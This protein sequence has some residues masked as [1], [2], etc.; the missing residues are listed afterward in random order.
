MHD[1]RNLSSADVSKESSTQ[2]PTRSTSPQQPQTPPPTT[3]SP[4]YTSPEKA[5]E[6]RELHPEELTAH[7][8]T[9]GSQAVV[10]SSHMLSHLP[11]VNG[12]SVEISR[13]ART[14]AE[15]HSGDQFSDGQAT[16]SSPQELQMVVNLKAE[17]FHTTRLLTQARQQARAYAETCSELRQTC[18]GLEK[19]KQTLALE[20]QDARERLHVCQTR[21]DE[22]R[23]ETA[24]AKLKVVSLTAERD[25]LATKV[26]EAWDRVVELSG[27]LRGQEEEVKRLQED[28]VEARHGKDLVTQQ[29]TTVQSQLHLLQEQLSAGGADVRALEVARER[30][31]ASL[32][33]AAQR[34]ADVLSDVAYDYQDSVAYGSEGFQSGSQSGQ[35]IFRI[36]TAST[37]EEDAAAEAGRENPPHVVLSPAFRPAP[38]STSSASPH[39]AAEASR[40]HAEHLL[41][42][43]GAVIWGDL[44]K[45]FVEEVPAPDRPSAPLQH[46][47][48]LHQQLNEEGPRKPSEGAMAATPPEHKSPSAAQQCVTKRHHTKLSPSV[49]SLHP[50]TASLSEQVFVRTALAP[51]LLSMKHVAATLGAVRHEHRRTVAEAEHFHRRLEET[52]RELE[53]TQKALRGQEAQSGTFHS[54]VLQLQQQVQQAEEALRQHESQDTQRRAELASVLRC[55][56]D[57]A[58]IQHSVERLLVQQ[59]ELHK[60]LGQLEAA[61][62]RER[63]DV[64][65]NGERADASRDGHLRRQ[66]EEHERPQQQKTDRE[67][68][69][70]KGG[71]SDAWR[72]QEGQ[73]QQEIEAGVSLQA[74]A[75]DDLDAGNPAHLPSSYAQRNLS[76]APHSLLGTPRLHHLVRDGAAADVDPYAQL[77]AEFTEVPSGACAD[78]RRYGTL[79]APPLPLLPH[80]SS[81]VYTPT[82]LA[83]SHTSSAAQEKGAASVS[84]ESQPA[85]PLSRPV[86]RTYPAPLPDA[87]PSSPFA[88]SPSSRPPL[89]NAATTERLLL[90]SLYGDLQ[91]Q[92]KSAL[93]SPPSP[94]PLPVPPSGAH[95][96]LRSRMDYHEYSGGSGDGDIDPSSL[97]AAE[98]LQVIE[99]LNRRVSGALHRPPRP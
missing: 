41:R 88:S 33:E 3:S 50:S 96:Q 61:R 74:A 98:V 58:L 53:E 37:T 99:A 2:A 71:G 66:E 38:T 26:Q 91:R 83:Q 92:S 1:T 30:L 23:R 80:S 32:H 62:R 19:D 51:I 89:H 27:A 84:L 22:H 31:A 77:P 55:R 57:W 65:M 85:V 42:N 44:S 54:Q 16:P 70:A 90:N 28:V 60:D 20:L 13:S 39:R 72:S 82:H 34:L 78:A 35:Q 46:D 64:K 15:A 69:V 86:S 18:R 5:S 56:E 75:E 48:Q 14:L 52:Q 93:R 73:R 63:E 9:T 29:Q 11:K 81:L 67:V 68:Y 47:E 97:F 94:P 8:G 76:S 95:S 49:P 24:D 79:P 36:T 21:L 7:Q 25:E 4:P 12:T 45:G 59:T 6:P 43:A 17:L 10:S 40:L 87:S